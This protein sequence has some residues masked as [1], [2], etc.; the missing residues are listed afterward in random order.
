MVPVTALSLLL[1]HPDALDSSAT[2]AA[3]QATV[4]CCVHWSAPAR[5]AGRTAISQCIRAAPSSV[6]DASSRRI[7]S[8]GEM[9]PSTGP[10]QL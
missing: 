1:Q 7:Q 2:A 4:L 9:R 8:S 6:G 3:A 10:S 5:R